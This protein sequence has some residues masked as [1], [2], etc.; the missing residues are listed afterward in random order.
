MLFQNTLISRLSTEKYAIIILLCQPQKIFLFFENIC[1]YYQ[2]SSNG[3]STVFVLVPEHLMH[4][5]NNLISLLSTAEKYEIIFLL[6]QPQKIFL[7]FENIC[8]YY[9]GSSNG[10]CTVF[11]LRTD[12]LMPF[13][14]TLIFRLSSA[15]NYAFI[16]IL[17]QPQKIF[18][19]FEN[20]CEYYQG[21]S[22]GLSTVFVLTTEHLMPFQNTLIPQLFSA[23]KYQIIF[24][25]C[26]P[27]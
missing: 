17:C 4:F 20:I 18:L 7:F 16:F 11:V 22:N 14:N 10:Q 19:F 27:Q 12:H 9:Q 21:S 26:Q 24:L 23:E 6:P 15:V 5:Q 8:E 3:L 2:G 13:P 1:E 25:L